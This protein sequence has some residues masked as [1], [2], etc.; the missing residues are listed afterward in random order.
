MH[1]SPQQA[2][3]GVGFVGAALESRTSLRSLGKTRDGLAGIEAR[4]PLPVCVFPAFVFPGGKASWE[5]GPVQARTQYVCVKEYPGLLRPG[6][7]MWIGLAWLPTNR[8]SPVRSFASCGLGQS[9][10]LDGP[11]P[12]IATL[13]FFPRREEGRSG[14]S[15]SLLPS[16]SRGRRCLPR[17][18][19]QSS[20]ARWASSSTGGC[21]C[22]ALLG[23][24]RAAVP[25]SSA[26]S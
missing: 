13:H 11:A 2:G 4:K 23:V 18:P 17:T 5:P 14:G 21:R 15:W 16:A 1:G 6:Y 19:S 25:G 7:A 9:P 12:A 22:Q 24:R 20:E 8:A 26:L 3:D 10:A